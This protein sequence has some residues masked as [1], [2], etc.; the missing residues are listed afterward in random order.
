MGDRE[1]VGGWGLGV[2]KGELSLAEVN[3]REQ[4]PPQKKAQF[5]R[6][7][8]IQKDD[9]NEKERKYKDVC[10]FSCVATLGRSK[11]G[12]KQRERKRART[13]ERNTEQQE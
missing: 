9:K 13:E 8:E 2:L 3:A 12:R 1:F 7:S 4:E 6:R 11:K 10:L 5:L